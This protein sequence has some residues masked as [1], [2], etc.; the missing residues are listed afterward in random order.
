M[1]LKAVEKEVSRFLSSADPEVLCITGKW[2]VGKTY[3][4]TRFIEAAAKDGTF[5]S[6]AYAYVSLFGVESIDRLRASIFEN[7]LDKKLIGEPA[8]VET[9]GKNITAAMEKGGRLLGSWA[10]YIPVV[11]DYEKAITS[12]MS[13]L[14]VRNALVV[15]DDIERKSAGLTVRDVFGM[16]SFLKEQRACKVVII[17]NRDALPADEQ[18]EFNRYFEKTVD[19]VVSFDPTPSESAGIAFPGDDESVKLLK[20]FSV[21]LGISNI[22]VMRKIRAHVIRLLPLVQGLHPRVSRQLIH[23]MTLVGFAHYDAAGPSAEFLKD[24]WFKSIF[25]DDGPELTPDEQAWSTSLSEYGFGALDDFDQTLLRGL[26][27]GAFDEDRLKAEAVN[28]DN[29][30]RA[31]DHEGSFSEGWDLFHN[32]FDLNA[33]D[34]V[35]TLRD[36]FP[37]AAKFVSPANLDGTVRLM[38]ELDRPDVAAEMIAE[39]VEAHKDS[40][41]RFDLNDYSF[42]GEVR[43]QDVIAAFN[44]KWNS[45]VDERDPG[46][47]LINIAKNSGWNPADITLLARLT[48]EDFVRIFKRTSGTDLSR[49]IKAALRFGRMAEPV[50]R[51]IGRRAGDALR[52]IGAEGRINELRVRRYLG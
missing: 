17:L 20:E 1:T 51:E 46:E 3:A 35:S 43:D 44:A 33:N 26:E 39:Y 22:R 10:K 28:L 45:V 4:W 52:Q 27:M 41:G 14:A 12:A 11:K 16:A 2:G 42:S 30:F 8:T 32:S 6:A 18:E 21:Q 40:P 19:A 36:E 38:K 48:V 34:V 24:R 50:E 25:R 29:S 9:F 13:F 23:T 5:S 37:R 7:L 49:A 47:V 15:I 31:Q